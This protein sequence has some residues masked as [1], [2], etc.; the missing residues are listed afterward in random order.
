MLL[1]KTK[2]PSRDDMLQDSQLPPGVPIHR[3]HF[4]ADGAI[5]YY[6]D[7]ARYANLDL[8]GDKVITRIFRYWVADKK[9][10][11][12]HF[13][14]KDVVV[15]EDGS[16]EMQRQYYPIFGLDYTDEKLNIY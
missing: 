5:D 3:A 12:L 14:D 7:L 2:L 13:K 15:Y 4:L 6:D 16:V 9:N 8:L 1:G 11:L 10:D